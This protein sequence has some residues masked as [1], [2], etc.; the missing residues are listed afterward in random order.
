MP[1][2]R[3]VKGV[4]AQ[5]RYGG[6][7]QVTGEGQR[8][9][10][11]TPPWLLAQVNRRWPIDF[12]PC[13]YPKQDWNGLQIPWH[14]TAWVNPPYGFQPAQWIE[15][16]LDEIDAGRV[17]RVVVLVPSRTDTIW[18]HEL[19]IPNAT[20][21]C[22]I[23]NRIQF[24]HDGVHHKNHPA[25]PSVILEFAAGAPKGCPRIESWKLAQGTKPEISED[26]F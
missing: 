18:W 20:T 10:W 7:D 21:I 4:A 6:R 2:R 26:E 23:K 9:T 24:D 14:G 19:V 16:T 1:R 17:Q 15:K 3:A 11:R 22:F 12:D 5:V 13:P 8:P 25:F